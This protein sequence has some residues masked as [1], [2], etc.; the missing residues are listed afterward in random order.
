VFLAISWAFFSSPFFICNIKKGALKG[1]CRNPCLDFSLCVSVY[2]YIYFHFK[3]EVLRKGFS[4]EA[5]HECLE[6]YADLSIIAVDQSRTRI[7]FIG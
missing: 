4:V 2:I 6:E 1:L 5:F 3:A 7:D